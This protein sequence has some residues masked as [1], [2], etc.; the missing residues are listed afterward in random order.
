MIMLILKIFVDSI[1]FIKFIWIIWIT[2]SIIFLKFIWITLITHS[3]NSII[4]I[5]FRLITWINSIALIFLLT[6]GIINLL[7]FRLLDDL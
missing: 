4:F 6:K 1:I 2:H 7:V 3:M 5:M